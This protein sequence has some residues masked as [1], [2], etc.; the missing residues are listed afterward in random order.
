M[1]K[2]FKKAL[3][4][5][6]LCLI[7][8]T[9]GYTLKSLFYKENNNVN[10]KINLKEKQ[11]VSENV[12]TIE[13]EKTDDN[14]EDKALENNNSNNTSKADENKPSND[15]ATVKSNSNNNSSNNNIKSETEN[16]KKNN[17]NSNVSNN[18]SNNISSSATQDKNPSCV[19][20]KFDMN[21]VRADFNTF[22]ECKAMGDKYMNSYGYYCDSYQDNCGTTYYMLTL[23]DTNGNLFDYHSI[24]IP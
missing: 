12:D 3:K 5:I 21:W 10:E 18:S 7:I 8:F 2:K 24:Q 6:I 13:D 20:K 17:D 23:F 15:S 19:P 4:L 14:K 9:I 22:D 1:S 11:N 16:S